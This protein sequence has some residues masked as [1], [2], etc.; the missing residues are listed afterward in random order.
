M[1]CLQFYLQ[2][3]TNNEIIVKKPPKV[4]GF[5]TPPSIDQSKTFT[6]LLKFNILDF[7]TSIHV[8]V[9]RIEYVSYWQDPYQIRIDTADDRIVPALDKTCIN[10]FSNI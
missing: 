7:E 1:V 2:L 6:L 8:H 9:Y 3:F 10:K 4:F 5:K